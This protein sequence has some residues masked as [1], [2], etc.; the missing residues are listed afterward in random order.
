L[1]SATPVGI[2]SV[3]LATRRIVMAAARLVEDIPE[4]QEYLASFIL[5]RLMSNLDLAADCSSLWY[6]TRRP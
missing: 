3:R 1:L 4:E 2:E 5:R 6:V